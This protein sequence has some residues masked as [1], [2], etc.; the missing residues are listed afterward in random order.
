[1]ALD[2]G[3]ARVIGSQDEK[4]AGVKDDGHVLEG[5]PLVVGLSPLGN[6]LHDVNGTL[7]SRQSRSACGKSL[8]RLLG[9]AGCARPDR[10]P[11]A[12]RGQ[13]G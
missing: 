4:Q 6:E 8:E 5:E 7:P 2:C 11:L 1:M 12:A 9:R 3:A 13:Y 10:I